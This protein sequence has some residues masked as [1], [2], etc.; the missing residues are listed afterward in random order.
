MSWIDV[1][2][3]AAVVLVGVIGIFRGVQKSAVALGAFLV[4]F[5]L[6]FFLANVIAEAML[7]IDGIKMFVLGDGVGEGAQWSLA[8]WI[9]SGINGIQDDKS[10]IFVNF[11]KPIYDIVNSAQVAIPAGAGVSPQAVGFS[12][13]GAFMILSAICGVGIFI[14]VRFLLI[15]VTVII[16]SF[17]GKKKTALSRVFGFVLGAV[18]GALWMFA[19][20]VVFSCFGGYTFVSGIQSMENEYE[21]NAVVC[22]YFN[23]WAYG[24]RNKLLLPDRDAYGRIVEMVYKKQAGTD[25]NAEPLPYERL[26]VFVGASN[27]GYDTNPWS[28]TEQK[29]R[30][31]DE[32]VA[33]GK[34]R[35]AS[36]FAKTGF[37]AAI[38]A[39]LDYNKAI[40]EKIGNMSDADLSKLSTDEFKKMADLFDNNSENDNVNM[41]MDNLWKALRD[42][43]RDYATLPD[44]NAPNA[45]SIFN[46]TL[47]GDYNAVKLAWNDLKSKYSAYEELFGAF[48]NNEL[49]EKKTY[50]DAVEAAKKPPVSDESATTGDGE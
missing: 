42:Y 35:T 1:A 44:K 23:E 8:K 29:K 10:F 50:T 24:L 27:A 11:Y 31:F 37:D 45:E 20:T 36:E 16:K 22:G 6:A 41:R 30:A 34:E 33:G 2:I 48:P 18:R 40:Y 17:I 26:R 25:P 28:I 5:I 3:L 49:P 39:I 46:S 19:I 32:S 21:N 38:Q 7:G 43:E 47:S 12:M 14:I 15:I 4:S 9:Y 13:Y